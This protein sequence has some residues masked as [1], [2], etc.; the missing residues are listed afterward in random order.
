MCAVYAV[1]ARYVL[2]CA[3]GEDATV[4]E[5]HEGRREKERKEEKEGK[6]GP[7][8]LPERPFLSGEGALEEIG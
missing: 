1:F 3:F 6:L 2:L 5:N 8:A 4:T 7:A